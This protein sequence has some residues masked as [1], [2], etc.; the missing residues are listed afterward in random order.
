M[1]IT[2]SL[3]VAAK[4]TQ[5]QS[6]ELLLRGNLGLRPDGN[7]HMR[8]EGVYARI[9]N[10]SGLR[11]EV[12]REDYSVDA[13]LCIYFDMES[14]E[15]T[16]EGKRII[17]RVTATVLRYE[18]GD[19]VLLWVSEIPVLRRFSGQVFVAKEC[20]VLVTEQLDAAG[21][22]YE[23]RELPSPLLQQR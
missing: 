5:S 7:N 21:I 4:M 17:G 10:I 13:N 15:D 11:Q 14:S 22:V 9:G 3:M 18:T 23:R 19:V 6:R 8:G 20:S 1:S 12:V 2:H 16:E